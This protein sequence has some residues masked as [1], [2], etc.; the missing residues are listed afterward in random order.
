MAYPKNVSKGADVV[1]II[2]IF[3]YAMGYS[4]GL[5]PAA[6]V[7]SSEV[8]SARPDSFYFEATQ[9]T[10]FS[11]CKDLSHRCPGPWPQL[12]R[13]RR[14][15]WQHPRLQDLAPGPGPLGKWYLLLLHVR[16]LCLCS[17]RQIS[18]L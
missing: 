6:W 4:L 5:G 7:Y 13:K 1:C 14:V 18:T 9:D 8:S 2:F 17:G 3:V 16:Q 10:D 15:H 12:C 11:L